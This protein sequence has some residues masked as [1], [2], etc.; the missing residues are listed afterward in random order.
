MTSTYDVWFTVIE[1]VQ[2]MRTEHLDIMEG[3]GYS[4][5]DGPFVE[6]KGPK[7]IHRYVVARK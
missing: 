3:S 5:L 2:E 7:T 4:V 6:R 1:K